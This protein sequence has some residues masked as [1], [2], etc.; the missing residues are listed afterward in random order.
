M[1][2]KAQGFFPQKENF[3]FELKEEFLGRH[4]NVDYVGNGAVFRATGGK[5]VEVGEDFIE[6]VGK[7]TVVIIVAGI[8]NPFKKSASKIIIPILRIVDVQKP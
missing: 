5:L 7:I 2:D 3:V 6:I 1:K 8:P 4:V